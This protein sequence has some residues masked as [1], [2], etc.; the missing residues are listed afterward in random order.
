LR[1][2]TWGEPDVWLEVTP[3]R[4][5]F[6]EVENGQNHPD[7]NVLKVWPWLEEN[8]DKS[9]F[10]IHAFYLKGIHSHG[11]AS[12]GNRTRIS[13]WIGK[14]VHEL[15]PARFQYYR[16]EVSVDG[17]SLTCAEAARTA[18]EQWRK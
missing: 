15:L 17:G 10:L 18:F 14:R 1:L 9:V 3:N 4:Y 7:T 16:L 6:V 5:L 12:K 2:G 11:R 13:S 8:P